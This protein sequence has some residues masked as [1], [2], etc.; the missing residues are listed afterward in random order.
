[1]NT[2]LDDVF[3]PLSNNNSVFK[4]DCITFDDHTSVDNTFFHNS[5]VKTVFF[6]I[7]QIHILKRTTKRQMIANQTH[8]NLI[9]S[10]SI[11]EGIV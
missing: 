6:Q 2:G 9:M 4:K 8:P 11:Y 10:L 5:F 3:L 1:M 7:L